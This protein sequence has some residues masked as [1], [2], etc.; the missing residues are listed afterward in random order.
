MLCTCISSNHHCISSS[1]LRVRDQRVNQFPPLLSVPCCLTPTCRTSP[2]CHPSISV[3]VDHEDG[4]QQS[5]LPG[6]VYG[7]SDNF[8][9]VKNQPGGLLYG[10]QMGK[11]AVSVGKLL[12][13]DQVYACSR[14]RRLWAVLYVTTMSCIHVRFIDY[15]TSAAQTKDVFFV[16]CALNSKR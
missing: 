6:Y 12:E 8:S 1:V 14:H 10:I 11:L 4:C 7:G 16:K 3:L 15:V 9:I 5:V 2:G 13:V